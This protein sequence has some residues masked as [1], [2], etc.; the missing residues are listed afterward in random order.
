MAWNILEQSHLFIDDVAWNILGQRGLYKQALFTPNVK[1]HYYNICSYSVFS[2]SVLVLGFWIFQGKKGVGQ[3]LGSMAAQAYQ[4]L[5]FAHSQWDSGWMEHCVALMSMSIY[6]RRTIIT[7]SA[8][9]ILWTRHK[10]GNGRH[11][12]QAMEVAKLAMMKKMSAD[13]KSKG[14]NT[15]CTCDLHCQ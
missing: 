6:T 13:S 11:W 8:Q 1:T 7:G 3:K 14:K 2:A 12:K 9:K 4:K 15:E 5:L 10:K